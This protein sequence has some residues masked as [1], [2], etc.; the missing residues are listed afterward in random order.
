MASD[1]NGNQWYQPL[2]GL[3]SVGSYQIAGIPFATGSL[4]IDSVTVTEVCF[5]LVTKFVVI[6]NNSSNDMRVGFSENG[7]NGSN[8]FILGN[9]ESYSGDLRITKLYLR[10]DINTAEAT[11]VAGLTGIGAGNLPN[12]WS[13]SVGVG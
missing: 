13:G 5:P 11:I 6:R 3:G 12:S 4:A 1:S 7:I 8:Y 9:K 2:S 10:G